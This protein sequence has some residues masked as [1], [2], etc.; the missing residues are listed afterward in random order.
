M[1]KTWFTAIAALVFV[2]VLCSESLHAGQ[3]ASPLATTHVHAFNPEVKS[4]LQDLKQALLAPRTPLAFDNGTTAENCAQYL[5]QLSAGQPEE[6]VHGAAIRAEYLVCDAVRFIANEPFTLGTDTAPSHGAKALFE[7]LDLRSFP[8][9]L[10][11]RADAQRLTLKQLLASAQV[12][13]TPTSVEGETD[14]QVFSLHIA[15]VVN[16]PASSGNVKTRQSE[17]I[18]WVADE[19][20]SGNYRSYRTLIVRPPT[21][22]SGGR[23]TGWVYPPQ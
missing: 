12:T 13:M 11:N 4:A 1:Q 20:K 22:G 6:S 9:S 2:L 3:R 14:E 10:R 19:M 23:Y 8:S 16:R 18:V 7:R 21:Q 15:A 5:N 17:W